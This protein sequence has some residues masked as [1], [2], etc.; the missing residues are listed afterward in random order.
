MPQGEEMFKYHGYSG[1]CPK[2]P[3]PKKTVL[4]ERDI[5][6]AMIRTLCNMVSTSD[7]KYAAYRRLHPTANSSEVLREMPNE[8]A[9]IEALVREIAERE[10]AAQE[11]PM[12]TYLP[13]EMT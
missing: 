4:T 13:P 7:M 1:Q 3:L 10:L 6:I 12:D 2:P 9:K 11:I 5:N 8:P